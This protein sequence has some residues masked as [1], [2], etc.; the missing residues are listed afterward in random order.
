M[1][2]AGLAVLLLDIQ[3][4]EIAHQW[5]P[6]TAGHRPRRNCWP[7]VSAVPWGSGAIT[8]L[9][10]PIPLNAPPDTLKHVRHSPRGPLGSGARGLGGSTFVLPRPLYFRCQPGINRL[11]GP[12]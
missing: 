10:Y 2:L 1:G 5:P 7:A 8:L 4:Q 11:S 9:E 12:L 6:R 3:C